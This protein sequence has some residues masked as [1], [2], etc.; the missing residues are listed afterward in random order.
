MRFWDFEWWIRSSS[1]DVRCEILPCANDYML[2]PIVRERYKVSLTSTNTTSLGHFP[3]FR[4][5]H[6]SV[7]SNIRRLQGSIGDAAI[8]E[9]Y[10]S[11]RAC[12]KQFT[13]RGHYTK[14]ATRVLFFIIIVYHKD[15][16]S[17]H[18]IY[19]NTRIFYRWNL[20]LVMPKP[21]FL[22]ARVQSTLLMPS[23]PRNDNTLPDY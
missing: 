13:Q 7:R 22:C 15:T 2:L 10:R 5:I 6:K 21:S 11:R 20:L 3:Y 4:E 18:N 16:Y 17:E 1:E 8:Y 23:T 14:H 9:R 19:T 12:G